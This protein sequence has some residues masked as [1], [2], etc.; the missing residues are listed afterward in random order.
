MQSTVLAR[1][2]YIDAS[3]ATETVEELNSLN[4]TDDTT[5]SEHSVDFIHKFD[6]SSRYYFVEIELSRIAE[7]ES[8]EVA[9]FR[10]ERLVLPPG[11]PPGTIDPN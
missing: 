4:I 6:F 3:G 9:G 11:P 10:L 2:A 8:S 5:L 1:L 7:G